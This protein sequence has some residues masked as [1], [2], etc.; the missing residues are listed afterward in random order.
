MVR[1]SFVWVFCLSLI[2][3]IANAFV[4]DVDRCPTYPSG[5][6]TV[7]E[8]HFD[9]FAISPDV[10]VKVSQSSYNDD[11]TI[12]IT[13]D[14]REANL[15]IADELD[16]ADIVICRSGPSGILSARDITTVKVENFSIA[17]DIRVGTTTNIVGAEYILFNYS[18]AFSDDEAA[19]FFAVLWKRVQ[20]QEQR[21]VTAYQLQYRQNGAWVGG[22]LYGSA[23]ECSDA[24][25]A[26]GVIG[27]RCREVQVEQ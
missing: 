3:T 26:P 27:A 15:I 9:Q 24:Q 1:L 14:P 5:A 7:Y 16:Q 6:N 17:P 12:A 11:I 25:W 21:T 20:D 22:P 2:G 19:A 8:F 10:T 23:W 4:V 13:D 18:E